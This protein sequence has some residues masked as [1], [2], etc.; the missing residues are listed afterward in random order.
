M[1][2]PFPSSEYLPL[3]LLAKQ[4]FDVN[5]IR[6]YTMTDTLANLTSGE[7]YKAPR[8]PLHT[9]AAWFLTA[10]PVIEPRSTVT[11]S[12]Y[13]ITPHIATKWLGYNTHNRKIRVHDLEKLT[14]DIKAD[15]W[16]LDGNPIR[17]AVKNGKTYLAD[18]QHRLRAIAAAGKSVPSVVVTG[19]TAEAQDVID[20]GSKR[21]FSDRLTLSE[22]PNARH[23]ASMLRKVWQYQTGN[24]RTGSVQPSHTQLWGLLQALPDV[25]TDVRRGMNVNAA[26]R[27]PI[28][29]YAM[30]SHVFRTIDEKDAE[31]FFAKLTSGDNLPS[32]SP[33]LAL[34]TRLMNNALAKA[35][36]TDV[37][38]AALTV[39]A[40]NGFRKGE[41]KPLKW[42]AGRAEF[43]LP[44]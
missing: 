27:G 26:V 17:F 21:T 40:W 12:V 7:P 6:P 34:R 8:Q 20:T 35:K 10:P 41:S 42:T 3:H 43:P 9:S 29:V 4:G 28:G 24:L 1:P 18:G 16:V 37:E 14:A 30:A 11:V 39:K 31:A 19:L 15:A 36:I 33:I 22:V 32:G 44:V 2:S 38:I 23:T 5:A 13:T 25:Q